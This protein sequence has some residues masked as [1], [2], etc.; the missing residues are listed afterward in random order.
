MLKRILKNCLLVVLASSINAPVIAADISAT[1]NGRTR[2]WLE[3]VA[4]KDGSST[5]QMKADGRLGGSV[6]AESG[7]WTTT[8]FQNMDLDSDAGNAGPT[9]LDQKITLGNDSLD[10]TLGRFSPYGVSKGMAYAVG[11]ISDDAAFWVG[12]NVPTTD[13]TNHLTVDVKE[14]GL[15]VIYALNNYG[16]AGNDARNET[17]IGAVYGKVFGTV[18]LAVEVLSASSAI[19][20]KD[21]DAT[22]GGDYDGAAFGSLA[23][24]VGYAISNKMGVAINYESNSNTAGTSGAKADKNS[25]IEL[26]FDLGFDDISGISVG[27][28]TKVNDKE[29]ANVGQSTLIS[30]AFLIR[31][32]I[33]NLYTNFLSITEKD[34][35]DDDDDDGVDDAVTNVA[36]GIEVNF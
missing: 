12:E 10:I 7:S 34:D 21:K 15:T 22:K 31:L 24:G 32:G 13:V 3:S 29:S 18:D 26:W 9:I 23:L 30:L 25:I 17:M 36:A 19:D 6:S 8:A 16:D 2:A 33:A 35:D 5:M 27:Y 20:E 14:L 28:A 1:V 11:P 4:V